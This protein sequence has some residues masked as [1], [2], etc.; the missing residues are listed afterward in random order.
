[1]S[2]LRSSSD[3]RNDRATASFAVA[4]R[5]S[6]TSVSLLSAVLA[7]A[8]L[9]PSRIG[10]FLGFAGLTA[11][12]SLSDLGLNQSA[13]LAAASQPSDDP[14]PI[15]EASIAVLVPTVTLTSAL[16]LMAGAAFLAGTSGASLAPWI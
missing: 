11:F 7:V 3:R 10:V 9:S 14:S 6:G 15:R 16:Q 2:A 4:T 5:L 1:M 12:S 13:L 8:L